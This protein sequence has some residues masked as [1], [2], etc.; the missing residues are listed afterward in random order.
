MCEKNKYFNVQPTGGFSTD[1]DKRKDTDVVRHTTEQTYG[2]IG[3]ETPD[4]SGLK[5]DRWGETICFRRLCNWRGPLGSCRAAWCEKAA[6]R[7]FYFHFFDG[8]F[9]PKATKLQFSSNACAFLVLYCHPVIKFVFNGRRVEL[10]LSP[11]ITNFAG[12]SHR[13]FFDDLPTA[14][15]SRIGEPHPSKFLLHFTKNGRGQHSL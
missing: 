1:G 15:V 9:L 13:L 10:I 14:I 3:Q 6:A 12:E 7:V 2:D 5:M 8:F 4:A 11:F